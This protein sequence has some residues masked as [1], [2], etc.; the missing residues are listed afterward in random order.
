MCARKKVFVDVSSLDIRTNIV[1]KYPWPLDFLSREVVC[2]LLLL[3]VFALF[4]I[5]QM[6]GINLR[7]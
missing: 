6:V 4:C 2:V 5:F 1:C 7:L 3:F